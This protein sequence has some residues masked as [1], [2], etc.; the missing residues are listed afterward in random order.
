LSYVDWLNDQLLSGGREPTT[1]EI[2]NKEF[3]KTDA[4]DA[5]EGELPMPRTQGKPV[6]DEAMSVGVSIKSFFI[7][8]YI[9]RK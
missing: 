9:S 5:L 4:L 2:Y 3:L 8:P 1:K 6:T 7:Y